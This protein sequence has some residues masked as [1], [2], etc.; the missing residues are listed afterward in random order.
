MLD[1]A[2]QVVR[3]YSISFILDPLITDIM[4]IN[5]ERCRFLSLVFFSLEH[6][7]DSTVKAQ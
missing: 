7:T 4:C 3:I 1:G 6:W 5:D 2:C